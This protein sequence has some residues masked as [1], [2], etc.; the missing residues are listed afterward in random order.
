MQSIKSNAQSPSSSN[1]SCTQSLAGR[2][3]TISH[4]QTGRR[5]KKPTDPDQHDH[6]MAVNFKIGE[7]GQPRGQFLGNFI[8]IHIDHRKIM[9]HRERIAVLLQE[10]GRIFTVSEVG[11]GG[12]P[13][14][15]SR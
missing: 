7:Q 2:K 8:Y 14:C 3:T 12:R 4:S 10:S 9:I 11:G 6:D 15:C 1:R 5:K 13:F